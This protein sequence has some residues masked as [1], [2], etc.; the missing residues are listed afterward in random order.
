MSKP[1]KEII[2][3][4]KK[5]YELGYKKKLEKGDWFH[6]Q[7]STEHGVILNDGKIM[8][9]EDRDDRPDISI[10]SLE[11]GLEWLKEQCIKNEGDGGCFVHVGWS[12]FDEEWY[13]QVQ[14]DMNEPD[15]IL[16]YLCNTPHEAVLMA[17]VKVLESQ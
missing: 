1:T 6:T 8:L 17:M 7:Y 9:M 16:D 13:T 5:L 11:D 10:P 12:S 15:S 4:S 3:L 14:Y 2:E